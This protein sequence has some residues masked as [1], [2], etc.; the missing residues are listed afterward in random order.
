MYHGLRKAL[1]TGVNRA[2]AKDGRV[3]AVDEAYKRLDACV[4]SLGSALDNFEATWKAQAA[5]LQYVPTIASEVYSGSDAA[6][7]QVVS[8]ATDAAAS[9]ATSVSIPVLAPVRAELNEL[10]ERVQQL[11]AQRTEWTRALS[12]QKYYDDKYQKLLSSTEP[13]KEREKDREK[14]EEKEKR[15]LMKKVNAAEELQQVSTRLAES[16]EDVQRFKVAVADRVLVSI[17]GAQST[18]ARSADLTRVC[19]IAHASRLG[20]RQPPLPARDANLTEVLVGSS[21]RRS[22]ADYSLP[23]SASEPVLPLQERKQSSTRISG[24]PRPDYAPPRNLGAPTNTSPTVS[25]SSISYDARA[26]APAGGMPELPDMQASAPSSTRPVSAPSAHTWDK[27]TTPVDGLAF[28]FSNCT[29]STPYARSDYDDGVSIPSAP[30][31]PPSPGAEST[32]S[33]VNGIEMQFAT[34]PPI[35]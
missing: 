18:N 30:P 1:S 11:D 5:F 23:A 9:L 8:A 28:D 24:F 6:A 35:N 10:R 14:R 7:A 21:R 3:A 20:T 25:S 26:S 19:E 22:S 15:A 17:F 4:E 29:L 13:D 16:F 34:R 31:P 32:Y 12:D 2:V 27:T 33:A